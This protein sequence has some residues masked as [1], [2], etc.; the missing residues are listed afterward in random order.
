M[1]NNNPYYRI[2]RPSKES[3]LDKYVLDPK[4]A[5]DRIHLLKAYK[6]IEE[7]LLEIFKYVEPSDGNKNTYS[8]RIYSLFLRACTEFES[9][10]KSILRSNDYQKKDKKNKILEERFW[11]ITDYYLLNNVMKLDQYE[12]K[13]PN[14]IGIAEDFSNGFKPFFFDKEKNL[15][16]YKSYNSVKHNR[17]D[18][19]NEASLKN[20]IFAVSAVYVILYAQFGQY[21]LMIND[22]GEFIKDDCGYLYP[23][24]RGAFLIKPPQFSEDEK[25]SNF[26]EYR[27]FDF[28]T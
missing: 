26:D 10:A 5:K 8:H 9:N 21:S 13:I 6:I 27:N 20:L 3:P 18:K 17:F 16:W 12:V 28:S 7:D 22:E 14:W 2:Y 25:Y 4:Y 11:K 24:I 19:F 23:S 1:N 15:S